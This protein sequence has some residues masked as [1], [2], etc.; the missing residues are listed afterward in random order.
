MSDKH[1]HDHGHDHDHD[2]G[3]EHG[4]KH[5]DIKLPLKSAAPAPAPEPEPDRAIEDAGTTALSDA[6]RSSFFIVK[7]L[8][9]VLVVV[10]FASGFFVVRQQERVIVLRFGKPL[11]TGTQRLLGPGL[12]F[13]FPAPIDEVVRI[14]V[15]ELQTARS[16]AGWYYTTPEMEATKSEPPP[17]ASLSPASDGYTVTSD[18]NI[19]HVR[20]DIQYRVAD[21]LKYELGFT[22]SPD[23]VKNV[24]DEA[25]F[26]ASSQFTVDQVLT[27]DRLAFREKVLTRVRQ[28]AEEL[29]LGITVEQGNVEVI[30][31]RQTKAAFDAAL[32]ADIERRQTNDVARGYAGKILSAAEGQANSIINAAETDRARLVQAVAAEA[33]Y[34]KDQLPHYKA[35]QG[36][37]MERLRNDA[38]GRVMTNVTKWFVPQPAAGKSQELRLQLNRDP[39]KPVAPQDQPPGV[40]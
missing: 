19:I 37:F 14:P 32:G 26:F 30:P 38:M 24:L 6:L 13:G 25:L 5:D 22:S 21:P 12:H 39:E 27:S 10:F 9:V 8:M 40:R 35:N 16:T 28:R 18:G 23:L 1:D 17:G 11:G 36:L 20:A 29:G 4:H 15:A 2:H 33:E 3:H 34:F 31:P 7:F